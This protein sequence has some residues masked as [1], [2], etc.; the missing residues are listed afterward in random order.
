[1]PKGKGFAFSIKKAS[2]MD[3]EQLN[4]EKDE[5]HLKADL[6]KP[7]QVQKDQIVLIAKHG[8]LTIGLIWFGQLRAIGE[9]TPKK[10]G[11]IFLITTRT[12]FRR[13]GVGNKLLGR[14][15]A[16]FVR[17]QFAKVILGATGQSLGYYAR[18]TNYKRARING[19]PT[20]AFLWKPI[21]NPR[22]KKPR[23]KAF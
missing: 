6:P 20:L 23:K 2:A 5:F 4:R 9:K 17:N 10:I 16:Y 8:K 19:I 15:N 18:K 21:P 3:L 13:K 12:G 7:W 22:Q 11:Q 14:A 1:M